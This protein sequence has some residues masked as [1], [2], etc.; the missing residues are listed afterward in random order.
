MLSDHLT[1]SETYLPTGLNLSHFSSS[2]YLL[3]TRLLSSHTFLCTNK[4]N[5]MNAMKE[6]LTESSSVC[7]Y[8]SCRIQ[9]QKMQISWKEI[10]EVVGCS[11]K[12]L[13]WKAFK[14]H[15]QLLP[16]GSGIK[17]VCLHKWS[18]LTS[19]DLACFKET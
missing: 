8:P 15:L 10:E 7:P 5:T 6:R 1:A 2:L 3:F 12:G 14:S 19:Y 17:K 13:R 11:Q 9:V 16:V 4:C 18:K